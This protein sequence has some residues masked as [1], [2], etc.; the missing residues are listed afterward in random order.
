MLKK[1]K[2]RR[3]MI[4]GS[5]ITAIGGAVW[6][7]AGLLPVNIASNFGGFAGRTLGMKLVKDRNI[8]RNLKIAFPQLTPAE[9]DQMTAKIIDNV[10]R[11]MAEMPHLGAFRRG[12]EGTRIDIEGLE[13]LPKDK[14]SVFVGGH[15]SNWEVE[16]V[17]LCR[18]LGGLNTIYSPIGVPV[19]DRKLQM[20]RAETGAQYLPRNSSSLRTIFDDMEKGKS[21]AMLID[22]R[23]ATGP[24]VN[25][26]GRPAL[27]SSLP[28][29]LAM[30]FNVP[31][32]PVDGTRIT[33][34]H[35]RVRL[36]KPI[37]PDD[38]P[39]KGQA[40]AIAQAMMTAI[41]T[42]LRKSPEVWFCNKARWRDTAAASATV[43]ESDE[44]LP[45]TM[46]IR[47]EF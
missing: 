29:R 42:F 1:Q 33:P 26:F 22:Q 14:P 31:I 16:V 2:Q 11:V 45:E 5:L 28:A 47:E 7:I 18:H 38:F 4:G 23:V 13:H 8:A 12:E 36:H 9:I 34:S 27:A 35:F 41:E 17:A 43:A 32:I 19:I 3:T 39:E 37:Y 15:H 30:R 44:T 40:L 10:A 46:L 20:Y 24:T 6:G 25:F 21:V